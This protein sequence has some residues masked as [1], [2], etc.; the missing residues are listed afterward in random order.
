M[1]ISK[2]ITYPPPLRK[3]LHGNP[4]KNL[5]NGHFFQTITQNYSKKYILDIIKVVII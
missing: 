4:L 2:E 3:H 1:L 5:D